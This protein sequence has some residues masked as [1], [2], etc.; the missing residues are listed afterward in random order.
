MSEESNG[1]T[2]FPAWFMD[3][4]KR[5]RKKRHTAEEL[6]ETTGMSKSAILRGFDGLIEAEVVRDGRQSSYE[7]LDDDLQWLENEVAAGRIY[8][9]RVDR[10]KLAKS[11]AFLKK[12]SEELK[13]ECGRALD[14]NRVYNLKSDEN[15]LNAYEATQSAADGLNK[16][17]EEIADLS[18]KEPISIVA[19]AGLILT[20][21]S[22]NLEAV[23]ERYNELRKG[24]RNAEQP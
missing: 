16:M 15:F 20:H 10:K 4:K 11:K 6:A 12:K 17:L 8:P 7:Y 22:K 9:V 18:D 13:Q 24:D 21:L 19:S 2:R 14:A 3:L 23:R 1:A 5:K